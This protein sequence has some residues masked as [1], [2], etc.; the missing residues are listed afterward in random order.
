MESKLSYDEHY[1]WAKSKIKKLENSKKEVIIELASKLERSGMLVGS[2]CANISTNLSAD[3]YATDRYVRDVLDKTKYK[4]KY[5][6]NF[7]EDI[8]TSSE[9][10][11]EEELK[12]HE[13]L[14]SNSGEQVSA[15]PRTRDEEKIVPLSDFVGLERAI[16]ARDNTIKE[17]NEKIEIL[18]KN[19]EGANAEIEYLKQQEGSE[20]IVNIPPKLYGKLKNLV[21]I[22]IR[23]KIPFVRIEY[24]G[25]EARDVDTI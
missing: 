5:Q 17:L 16:D 18:E 10:T 11:W 7:T 12:S 24:E 23:D 14:V 9:L 8:G 4:R 2:I 6:N 19:M 13:I 1:A 3:G 20:G 15:K 22:A 25:N 21:I